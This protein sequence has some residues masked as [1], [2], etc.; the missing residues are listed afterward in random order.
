MKKSGLKSIV[1]VVLSVLLVV[2]LSSFVSAF[3]RIN[4]IMYDPSLTQQGSD[5][6]NEWI[7]IYNNG[8]SAV[9]L[10]SATLCGDA[11]LKG[12]YNTSDGNINLNTTFLLQPS[13]YA[14]ITDG[15]NG[16]TDGTEVYDNFN[17]DPNALAFHISGKN[18]LC[19]GLSNNGETLDITLNSESHSI[20][21]TSLTG[22]AGGNGKTL[23][24]YG[25]SFTESALI[26][27][28][29]GADNDQF[30][31]DF[32]RWIN[33]SSNNSVVV[34]LLNVSVN[35]TDVTAVDSVLINFNNSNFSMNNNRDVWYFEWN[36][37]LNS[38]ANYNLTIFF[39]DTN[40]FS[41]VD[42]LLDVTVD[43]GAPSFSNIV[44][45]PS[46]VYNT[47]N[48]TISSSWADPRGISTI[49]FE[50]N[51]TG[52]LQNYTANSL[53]NNNYSLL[54]NSSIL[55][56]Q[57]IV[58][59][60]SYGTDID[61]NVNNQ[62]G[63]QTFVVSNRAPTLSSSV[64]NITFSE[65]TVNSSITLTSSFS[66]DDSDTLTFSSTT[67]S[68]IAVS[69][70]Q[71]TGVV[72]L[73]PDGNFSGTNSINF[74]AGDGL[75]SI[76]SNEIVITITNVNDAPVLTAIG[77]LDASKNQLF[78]Y[79]VNATDVDVGDNLSFSSNSTLFTIN[80]STGK[81]NFTPIESQVGSE[82]INI[83]VNDSFGLQDNEIITFTVS[84]KAPQ[85]SSFSPLTNNTIASTVGSQTFNITSSDAD[86][87]S[88]G[89][90][91]YRNGTSIAT[92]VASITVSGLSSGIF[93][94]T[95]IVT[96]TSDAS[97]RNVWTLTVS[98]DIAS[99]NL[100][101]PILDL[102]ETQRQN[103]TNVVINQTSF[104]GIDFGNGILNFSGILNLE[105]AF[106][107]SDGL[108][109]VDSDNY[110]GLN[111]SASLAM[112]NL[113]FT[114][115]PLIFTAPGFGST[116]NANICP[117][118]ICTNI[119]Y[120]PSTGKL[121]FDVAHFT[122]FFT[123]TNTTNGA[124]IITSSALTN[125]IVDETYRYNVVTNDPDGDTL[126]YNLT[127]SPAGM[128]I[129]SDGLISF[130][131]S[132]LGNFSVTVNVSDGN[133]S[134]AQSYSL[135]VSQSA[136]LRISDLDIKVGSKSDK[137]VQNNSLISKEAEPGDK[138]IFK[139]E[140]ENFFTKEENLEIQ[141]IDIEITIENID[142]SDD[143]EE[144]SKDFDLNYGRSKDFEL[145]F[146]IPLEV[147]EGL[148][149]VLIEVEGVDENGT[150]HEIRY[151]LQLEVEKKNHELLITRSEISPS[152][153]TCGRKISFNVELMNTGSKDEEDVSLE[154][155]SSELGINSV[156]SGISIDE[157][158]SDNRFSKII[159]TEINEVEE[160]IY[161]ININA[162]YDTVLGDSK[163][164]EL[165][166]KDCLIYQEKKVFEQVE[167][168]EPEVE[169]ILP[170]PIKE[171]LPVVA[172]IKLS[173]KKT[174]DEVIIGLLVVMF[175]TTAMIVIGAGFVLLKR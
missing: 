150:I 98:G 49:L 28:T 124:P 168:S 164:L 114:K 155:L 42:T 65:D 20:D 121:E 1:L 106:N 136:K 60:K 62:M 154:I 7:E 147:D 137:N 30:A 102:N 72:T 59:W 66:D 138:V 107:I 91:W 87:D 157:G 14:L 115:T 92:N 128:S 36:T 119:A 15:E 11:L 120:N 40:G 2:S 63:V 23:I 93:N 22:F 51:A 79:D 86:Q 57:E 118:S 148:F 13:S 83:I 99:T 161:P 77:N 53:G 50:H 122:T 163:I 110:P 41:N 16:G 103:V 32:N 143:L 12:F 69:I 46:T 89:T 76:G 159:R 84:N 33:P 75:S 37:S 140:I 70:N 162:Y 169:V 142:D 3:V 26:N 108:V 111:K 126:I 174:D 81:F 170:D 151:E 131:S 105:D 156:T 153:V 4:E 25:G 61:G 85:I 35:V 17:V 38:D 31:P 74:T 18:T 88:L 135:I 173:S 149:D 47:L 134:D 90:E 117:D 101:S 113:N 133:L 64:Q 24:F 44:S 144:E 48:V 10:S 125:A 123:Q 145:E 58:A 146:K 5:N 96:D 175:L 71:T 8:S 158:D 171:I 34:G 67:P 9:N 68:D 132:S 56:N 29:P 130:T 39:N 129:N 78:F 73:T 21:Y 43:N 139:I 55:E 95:V 94:I 165:M 112:K 109:S 104:G 54:I 52:T 100:T 97:V 127:T 116:A 19:T 172:P 45:S 80:S 152:S 160:G 141:N 6:L 27:G 82:V 167:E 166:V